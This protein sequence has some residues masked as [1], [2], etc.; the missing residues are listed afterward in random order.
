MVI[1]L[2]WLNVRG[3]RDQSKVTHLLHDLLSFNLD[4]ATLFVTLTLVCCLF[5]IQGLAGQRYFLDDEALPG[6]DG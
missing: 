3:F 5:N 6:C 2:V 1:K 4:V